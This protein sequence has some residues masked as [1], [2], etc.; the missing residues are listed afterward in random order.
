MPPS[1][2]RTSEVRSEVCG[3]AFDDESGPTCTLPKGHDLHSCEMIEEETM[4][5][6]ENDV[7]ITEDFLAGAKAE[8]EHQLKRWGTTH[9]RNKAPAD[10]FWL[11]GYLSGKALAA[12]VKGDR[13]KALHHCISSAAVLANWHDAIRSGGPSL[14]V[15]HDPSK[16]LYENNPDPSRASDLEKHLGSGQ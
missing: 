7:P 14:K 9:D 4:N 15:E 12:A 2:P 1:E 10:W 5:D 11:L 3:A 13:E 16:A 8:K 6:Y